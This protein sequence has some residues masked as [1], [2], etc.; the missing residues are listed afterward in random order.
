[1]ELRD[2]DTLAQALF[3]RVASQVGV[4]TRNPEGDQWVELVCSG[5]ELDEEDRKAILVR[6]K[7]LGTRCRL[8]ATSFLEGLRSPSNRP[9]Q[10]DQAADDFRYQCPDCGSVE[11]E[12]CFPV[13]VRANEFDNREL[14]DLDGEATPEKDSDKG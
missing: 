8:V 5:A 7:H 9:A 12:L 4:L 14:W 2:A 11:V 10:Q 13:W 3:L 1:M 6:A